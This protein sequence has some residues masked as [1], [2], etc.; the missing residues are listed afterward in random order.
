MSELKLTPEQQAVVENQ[1]GSLLVSAAAGS[2]KTKVLVERLFRAVTEE[3]CNVDDFLIITYTK[4]AAA[5]LRSKI[6]AEL[7]RRIGQ[8]PGDRHLRRQMLLV[9]QAD[10][11]TVDAFCTTL[12]RENTH[13]LERA[14]DSACLSP[15]FRV[16][17]ENEARM[18]RER[19]LTRT[20][21]NFYED[22]DDGGELLANTLGFGRDDRRLESLVLE[23]Y[24]KI[25]SHA[26]PEK[27]LGQ[28][29]EIWK[30][31][32]G[33]P[34][35][36]RDTV[37]CR[38]LLSGVERTAR[39][40]KVQLSGV[41]M[42]TVGTPFEKGY[43]DRLREAG[44][45]LEELAAAASAGDWDAARERAEGVSFR[46][47]STPRGT[48][49]DPLAVQVR[50]LWAACKNEVKKIC[51]L[52]NLSSEEAMEDLKAAA[53]AMTALLRL[54]AAFGEDY[55][56]EKLRQNAADF[57]DQEHLA[58]KILV[59]E[60]G[61]PT[62][63]GGQISARYREIMVD[64]YQDTNEVQNS[65]FR[66]VSRSGE[67]LFTV[68]D[69]KQSIYRFRLA[70][71]TIFLK[72]YNTFKFYT[73]AADGEER[74][75]LLSKNFR[76]RQEIL[77]ATNFIFG[78][79]LSTE[80]G[81]MEYGDDESLHFG[82]SYYPPRTDCETEFHLIC[83]RQKRGGEERPVKRLTA[84]ARFVAQ[85]IRRL[86]DEKYPVTQGDGSL[87]PCRPEDIVILMRSPG[88]RTPD[89]AAALAEQRIPCSFRD[90]GDYFS[91]VE[92][93][94]LLA[95]LQVID[96][97]H[98]DVPLISVLRSPLFGFAPDRLAE[99]R[100][101]TP[102]GDYYTALE[103]AEGEDCRA[104][105]ALLSEL[106]LLA[107]DMSVHRL[108]WHLYNRLNVLGIFGAMDRGQTR[109]ENL[110]ALTEHAR[111]FEGSGYRGVFA[112]VTQLNR[113]I[114]M[115][116]APE[117]RGAGT[118]GG[119]VIMSIHSSK[120]LEFPIVI[121]TD[122]DHSFSRKDLEA[123]VLVH[124]QLGL[125]PVRVDLERRIQYP[126]MARRA[127][128]AALLRENKAEEQRI[129]Y[130]A[131]T[132]PKE[133]L[134]LVDTVFNAEKKLTD[135]LSVTSCPVMPEA[136]AGCKSFG[137]WILMPLLCRSEAAPLR[138]LAG[139]NVPGTYA[140]GDAPWQVFVHQA[141]DFREV[142]V[143]GAETGEQMKTG[144]DFD[145]SVL[146]FVYPWQQETTLPAKLTA[147]QLKGRE[148]DS[149]IAEDAA[150]K[151]HLR[152]LTQPRFRQR[153]G[154]TAAETGTATHLV[155]Q[156]LDFEDNDVAGQIARLKERRLLTEEQADAV[157]A[158]ELERFL[159]SPLAEELRHAE[160]IWREYRFTLLMDASAYDP[161]AASGDSILLQGI[162][163]CCF[164]APDGSLTVVDFKTDRVKGDR[165]LERA[166]GYRP[167]VEAYSMALNR[168]LERPVKRK[169]LYFLYAGEQVELK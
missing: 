31:L 43:A 160:K 120:G 79:I 109:K 146:E 39:Y 16:L 34:G 13:L 12:L 24:E 32:G 143:Q 137:D 9:Y 164:A 30:A 60:D 88:S 48:K 135:L 134:I 5:E 95:L 150:V 63:L 106:R 90:S 58:L 118:E 96:N 107:R 67:N 108:L 49:D 74:K 156:Y 121:L 54:T 15:D 122:L 111:R 93:S 76:S 92:I 61:S 53:P 142:S 158:D 50:N 3:G 86:L 81:E 124:P 161:A 62:E 148:A 129:L 59:N 100:A 28:N 125:G 56:R 27:W 98:Q 37:Y 94:V 38:T 169:I 145:P 102:D 115:G 40:W 112:F 41:E 101:G 152:P 114:E 167:Q 91:S 97:P 166:E 87:R 73:A 130:V 6:A 117:T 104:F 105:V 44:V 141:E 36:F 77:D 46:S 153:A 8:N 65:I 33:A 42:Q 82:A 157:M 159:R 4:A 140:G 66:A 7:N 10:I 168:V 126:T 25:Q 64:E 128:E 136:V 21:E 75:I 35:A 2:G 83:A 19:V 123:P 139:A 155:L 68:G 154:L 85:R 78:N 138:M 149:E 127:L 47:L 84:E 131:M 55:R 18:L 165:L 147:T 80:M 20:L 14:E 69:V 119:V 133:K 29:E 99:I 163:D 116:K 144:D 22:L 113:L 23:L 51:G 57:S 45:G 89:Y 162:V 70:D 1:G 72:K 71:P 17:D 132:R 110:I 52:M 103:Q 11:R 151:P 26:Y